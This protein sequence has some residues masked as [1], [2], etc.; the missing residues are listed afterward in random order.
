VV[1]KDLSESQHVLG[2][3]KPLLL[4]LPVMMLAHGV[5]VLIIEVV[6]EPVTCPLTEFSEATARAVRMSPI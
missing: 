2:G 5:K 6:Q 3:I 4:V 1:I